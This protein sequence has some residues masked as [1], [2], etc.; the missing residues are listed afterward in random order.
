M[1][2]QLCWLGWLSHKNGFGNLSSEFWLGNGNPHRLT[3][4]DDVMFRIDL[5][6]FKRNIKY[7]EDETFRVADKAEKF[8]L[9]I[10]GYNYGTSG[11]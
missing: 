2:E 7:T 5:K 10:G 11:V 8:R 6:D 4:T 1:F 9:L 3:A